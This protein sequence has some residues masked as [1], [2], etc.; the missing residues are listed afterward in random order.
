MQSSHANQN[1]GQPLGATI[2]GGHGA[3]SILRI[4][5][6]PGANS[7]TQSMNPLNLLSGSQGL[8]SNPITM[9]RVQQLSSYLQG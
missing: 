2:T 6:M 4:A 8:E 7:L 5:D 9:Q 3:S 1:P